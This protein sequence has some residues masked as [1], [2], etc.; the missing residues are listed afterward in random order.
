MINDVEVT[1]VVEESARVLLGSDSI[2]Q[3]GP[4]MGGEDFSA[5]LRK[6]PGCFF[7]LGTGNETKKDVLSTS[8]SE[9]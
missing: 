2:I 7:K 6:A 3:L 4:S 8:S 1:K 9:I 5:Y